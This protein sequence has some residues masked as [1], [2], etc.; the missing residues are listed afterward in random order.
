MTYNLGI[1]TPGKGKV[2]IP[3]KAPKQVYRRAI[4]TCPVFKSSGS[5]Y[6]GDYV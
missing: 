4:L 2:L 3:R 1:D 5:V 6:L